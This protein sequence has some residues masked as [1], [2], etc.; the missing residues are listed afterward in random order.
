LEAGPLDTAARYLTWISFWSE[1]ALRELLPALP[2]EDDPFADHRERLLR[3]LADGTTGAHPAGAAAA[4]D[5]STYLPDDLLM[6]G[7]KMTM[8]ASLEVRV[9]FCD[10]RL[11]E[12]VW[13]IDPKLR[14]GP[15]LKPLLRR[16]MGPLLPPAILRQP[17]RGFMVPSRAGSA[18]RSR[19]WP[20][21][22]C[23][24]RFFAVGD[25]WRSPPSAD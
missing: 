24:S 2:G 7:D 11:V 10:R 1:P 20:A 18:G 3:A 17:K 19:R 21:I 5:L 8:A 9:P 13:S 25:S 16:V 22:C 14:S 4:L 12:M 6:L 15:G 23:P